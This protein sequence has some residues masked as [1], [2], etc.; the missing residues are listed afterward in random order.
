MT[1]SSSTSPPPMR[2][3]KSSI[4]KDAIALNAAL[5]VKW[6][7]HEVPGLDKHRAEAVG[8]S[9]T[10]LKVGYSSGAAVI[11]HLPVLLQHAGSNARSLRRTAEIM[12]QNSKRWKEIEVATK[13]TSQHYKQLLISS[14]VREEAYRK[15]ADILKRIMERPGL[16]NVWE[17]SCPGLL[18]SKTREL[19]LQKEGTFAHQEALK[20]KLRI[21]LIYDAVA[22]LK[23]IEEGGRPIKVPDIEVKWRVVAT[24]ASEEQ[25]KILRQEQQLAAE[26]KK[27]GDGSETVDK[28]H[29]RLEESLP[30]SECDLKQQELL[31][32]PLEIFQLTYLELLDVSYNDLKE[33]PREVSQLKVLKKLYIQNNRLTALPS[34]LVSLS[35]SLTLLSAGNNPLEPALMQAYL[36]GLPKLLFFLKATRRPPKA[37]TDALARTAQLFDVLGYDVFNT[38]LPAYP[39]QPKP[40]TAARDLLK[41]PPAKLTPLG[42]P[43]TS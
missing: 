19:E 4:D 38:P 40:G 5:T 34:S 10:V 14:R 3:M 16:L 12:L 32:L 13:E 31:A 21:D 29:Q 33:L 2:S 9:P 42:R 18:K 27:I 28:Y 24:M 43:Y 26:L 25:A 37:T 22:E 35:E 1:T 30:N 39:G 15:A 17:N 8:M 11:K 23:K 6:G 20:E 36:S 41:G 7:A